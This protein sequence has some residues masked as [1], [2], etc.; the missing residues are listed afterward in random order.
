MKAVEFKRSLIVEHSYSAIAKE[1]ISLH[2]HTLLF[3]EVCQSDIII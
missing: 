3:T 2:K 1:T